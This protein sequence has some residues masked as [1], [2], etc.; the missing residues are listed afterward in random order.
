[1]WHTSRDAHHD[2][3]SIMMQFA[4]M[5]SA[6]SVFSKQKRI[7]HQFR[8]FHAMRSCNRSFWRLS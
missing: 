4:L 3:A 2:G 6:S 7:C 1:M 8:G 5:M